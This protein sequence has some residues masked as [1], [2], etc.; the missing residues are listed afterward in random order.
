[1]APSFCAVPGACVYRAEGSV[2][3]EPQINKGNGDAACHRLGNRDLLDRLTP[4]ALTPDDLNT[5]NA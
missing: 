2:C 4:A 3:D 1:M 5:P